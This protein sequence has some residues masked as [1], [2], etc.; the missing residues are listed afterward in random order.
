MHRGTFSAASLNAERIISKRLMLNVLSLRT[1]HTSGVGNGEHQG[2]TTRNIRG[3]HTS[4]PHSADNQDIT[5][6]R[7]AKPIV[8]RGYLAQPEII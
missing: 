8:W 3:W 1:G 7:C 4:D 5:K 6:P 2:L